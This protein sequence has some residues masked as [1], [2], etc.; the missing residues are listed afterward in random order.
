MQVLRAAD[1]PL[2][3]P[4]PAVNLELAGGLVFQLGRLGEQGQH[5]PIAEPGQDSGGGDRVA[6]VVAFSRQCQDLRII[7]QRV[8]AND[9]PAQRPGGIL[10]QH[11][12]RNAQRFDRLPVQLLHLQ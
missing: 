11:H 4:Q 9:L 1:R 12:G 8:P 2:H 10:H 7:R 6:A 5:H 3:Q